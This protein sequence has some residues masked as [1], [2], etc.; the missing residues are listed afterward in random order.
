[1]TPTQQKRASN[2]RAI[3]IGRLAKNKHHSSVEKALNKWVK[4]VGTSNRVLEEVTDVDSRGGLLKL[5]RFYDLE[6][7]VEVSDDES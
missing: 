3:A 6:P 2:N 1:M 4:E 7:V 5:M